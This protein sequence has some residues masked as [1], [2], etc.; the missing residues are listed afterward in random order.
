MMV[1]VIVKGSPILRKYLDSR[2][3]EVLPGEIPRDPFAGLPKVRE[4]DRGRVYIAMRDFE[5][6][7]GLWDTAQAKAREMGYDVEKDPAFLFRKH[8][9]D[10]ASMHRLLLR[11]GGVLAGKTLAHLG[12]S[13]GFYTRYLQ[14][15]GVDAIAVDNNPVGVEIAKAIGNR[16]V[17][18]EDLRIVEGLHSQTPVRQLPFA[19]GSLDFFASDRFLF[20]NFTLLE[21]GTPNSAVFHHPVSLLMLKDLHRALKPGGVGVIT[22]FFANWDSLRDTMK[23]IFEMGFEVLETNA[24]ATGPAT[25][26]LWDI[27]LKKTEPLAEDLIIQGPS[28]DF[29]KVNTGTALANI[30]AGGVVYVDPDLNF[31]LPPIQGGFSET[32]EE[33][34]L[35][36][37]VRDRCV[38]VRV[39]SG[40][41]ENYIWMSNPLKREPFEAAA[42]VIAVARKLVELGVNPQLS[43]TLVLSWAPGEKNPGDFI[44][45][46][47]GK[48][49][50]FWKGTL[51][52][53]CRFS[54]K[55]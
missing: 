3:I 15:L 48:P 10:Y 51:G 24:T 43:C 5:A 34:E 29:R 18:Q 49:Y 13:A 54:L 55:K 2:G 6:R 23:R 32:K 42:Q 36:R 53:V 7:N 33:N 40:V 35:A 46:Q 11:H 8:L 9:A 37:K 31:Y 28:R 14:E 38:S 1:E 50:H 39:M 26:D 22:E 47:D 19:D 16:R 25:N 20:S 45:D 30:K 4:V 41:G 52:D 12:A 21:T 17:M 44:L 27:A